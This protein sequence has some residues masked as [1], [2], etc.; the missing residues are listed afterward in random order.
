MTRGASVGRRTRF[1]MAFLL[2]PR[3]FRRAPYPFPVRGA[4]PI[5]WVFEPILRAYVVTVDGEPSL[6]EFADAL[7]SILT[8]PAAQRRLSLLVDLR[9]V[10]SVAN[11]LGDE[12]VARVGHY[13]SRFERLE[14]FLVVAASGHRPPGRLSSVTFG[15]TV[16][17]D[18]FDDMAAAV[19]AMAMGGLD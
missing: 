7:D 2:D 10:P 13:V 17:I 11:I 8:H 9:A 6:D 15:E 19:T 5:A 4:L 18:I 14:V 16:T 1:T 3:S 12:A